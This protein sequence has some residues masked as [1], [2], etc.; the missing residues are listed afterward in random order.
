MCN[1]FFLLY[2]TRNAESQSAD[3]ASMTV[4]EVTKLYISQ[5]LN[6]IETAKE[7]NVN[8]TVL[9]CFLQRNNITKDAKMVH[10]MDSARKAAERWK[11]LNS[12]AI[13]KEGE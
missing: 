5:G 9:R 3:G 10:R 1:L 13:T 11:M 2:I 4:E 7:L 6:L 8:L 12:T